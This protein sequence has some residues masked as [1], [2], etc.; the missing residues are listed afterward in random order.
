MGTAVCWLC[1]RKFSTRE[2]CFGVAI[3]IS[4]T[5]C[6]LEIAKKL[7]ELAFLRAMLN[8]YMVTK[9]KTHDFCFK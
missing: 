5:F 1:S 9:I 7:K 4:E 8:G 3:G 6:A 2:S